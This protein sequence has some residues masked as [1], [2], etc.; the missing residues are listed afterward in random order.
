MVEDPYGVDRYE[1]L[2]L[3]GTES[4]D[5][6]PSAVPRSHSSTLTTTPNFITPL[7]YEG[8]A[9]EI[10]HQIL[11]TPFGQEFITPR[12]GKEFDTPKHP[13]TRQIEGLLKTDLDNSVRSKDL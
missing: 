2:S 6:I 9:E 11:Q 12:S 10:T 5:C 1:K 13:L 8:S 3:S 4:L 7:D